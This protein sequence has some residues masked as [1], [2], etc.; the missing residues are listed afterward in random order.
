MKCETTVILPHF[1][2]EYH[3]A[4]RSYFATTNKCRDRKHIQILLTQTYARFPPKLSKS[5]SCYFIS[6]KAYQ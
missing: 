1:V 2:N 3:E 6:Y 5:K 4:Y